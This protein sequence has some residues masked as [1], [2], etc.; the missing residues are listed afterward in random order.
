[1]HSTLKK[2]RILGEYTTRFT[3]PDEPQFFQYLCVRVPHGKA[4]QGAGYGCSENEAEAFTSAIAE[5]IEHYCILYEQPNKYIKDSYKNLKKTAI[6]PERFVPFTKEQLN[7][8]QLKG[9][10]VTQNIILNWIEGFSL[11]NNRKVLVPASLVYAV[12]NSKDYHEPIIRFN[13]STGAACGPNSFFALYRGMCEIIERDAYMISFVNDIPKPKVDI[14]PNKF[15]AEM[16]RRI[17][18]YSLELNVISTQ[19]DFPVYTFAC[20]IFDRTGSGPAVSA[21]ISGRLEPEKAIKSATLEA[22]RRHIATRD[23]FYREKPLPMPEKSSLDWFLLN[24]QLWWSAPHMIERAMSFISDKTVAVD[25]LINNSDDSDEKKVAFLV[26]EL[27][28]KNCEVIFVDVTI[29]QVRE[30]GFCVVKVLIP[31]MVPLWRDERFRYEGIKRLYEVPSRLG[32]S[33]GLFK[34]V[35]EFS[36]HPF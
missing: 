5:A 10:N 11:T 32:Y 20:L 26:K 18:R 3:F 30:L 31:E 24:K 12:Y 29:P 4:V 28:E 33:A 36:I 9:F 6:D 7:T 27:K 17:E 35:H 21:G 14:V 34:N 2:Q 23:R 13:I 8:T 1:M 19:L 16:K 25:S 15:L 22:L